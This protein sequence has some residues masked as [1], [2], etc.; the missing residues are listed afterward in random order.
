MVGTNR[1]ESR[2]K[3][4]CTECTVLRNAWRSRRRSE[5]LLSRVMCRDKWPAKLTKIWG[6]EEKK[7]IGVRQVGVEVTRQGKARQGR[8]GKDETREMTGKNGCA[9]LSTES[10]L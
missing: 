2:Q 7:R 6:G 9:A 10:V 5:F 8:K 3:S 1:V 4:G